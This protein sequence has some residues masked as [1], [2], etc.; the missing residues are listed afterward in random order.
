MRISQGQLNLLD[1]CLRKF[2]Y[3]YLDQFVSPIAPEQ[4]ERML[5]GSRFHLLMQQQ[6]LGLPIDRVGEDDEL[7]QRLQTFMQSQPQLFQPTPAQ[8]RSSEHLETLEF[9]GALLT[10]IY[11]LLILAADRAQILDWKTHPRPL[12][13]HRLAEDWQTRLYL[14]VL[15]ESTTYLP[16]Q[17]SMTYW[18][19][20]GTEATAPQSRRFDYTATLHQQTRHDL[21]ERLH[22]WQTWLHRYQQ[23]EALP[24]VAIETGR[25]QTCQFAVRCQR[26]SPT[27]EAETVLELESIPEVAL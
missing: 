18:F 19:V 15:A 27:G 3:V 14:F 1:F 2:Q 8:Q 25:C 4:F 10:V 21:A 16:E 24:Q 11:D 23:G 6:E 17:I 7:Q 13:R 26:V 5:W 22:Q 9:Q 12:D 20:Q